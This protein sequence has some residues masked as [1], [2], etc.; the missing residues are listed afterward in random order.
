MQNIQRLK[1]ELKASKKAEKTKFCKFVNG[2]SGCKR[3]ACWF[4]HV[5]NE[6]LL[7]NIANVTAE[8]NAEMNNHQEYLNL[9][10]R[11]AKGLLVEAASGTCVSS[12]DVE[13]GG[14]SKQSTQV[15]EV[16]DPG[17]RECGV[18]TKVGI[19]ASQENLTNLNVKNLTFQ[20]DDESLEAA[21][22]DYGTITSSL[23]MRNPDGTSKGVGFVCFSSPEE[24]NAASNGM[25]GK[26]L[27]G[28]PIFVASA[29]PR[30]APR[31]VEPNAQR[32]AQDAPEHGWPRW[33]AARTMAVGF[34]NKELFGGS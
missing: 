33:A 4:R 11:A 2:K 24:A 10:E 26:V 6:Q 1:N 13:S 14:E 18:G 15:A 5:T 27:E 30:R 34:Q 32:V 22:E 19:R 25:N 29:E 20:M 31:D 16:R 9:K 21:F 8:L 28:R 23:I 17:L 3:N 7:S 12:G